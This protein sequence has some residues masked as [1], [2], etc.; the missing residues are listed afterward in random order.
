MP[1]SRHFAGRTVVRWGIIGCG[2]VTEV[3]SGPGFQKASG[4]QL[5]AVMRRNG[6]LAADYAKRHGVPRWYDSAAALIA[7]PDVDA[8]YIATPP[9]SHAEYALAAAAAGKPA[10]VEKP[11][12]RHGAECDRMVEAFQRANLPLFVAYY[13]RRLPCFLKVE[14]LLK[15]GAIGRL[16]G[17][18]YRLAE[19]HHRKGGIWRTDPALAGAGHFLDVGS[20]ALDLLDYLLGPLSDV[21]GTAVN[22]ASTYSVEDSVALSFRAARG[23]LGSMVWNFAGAVSDDTMRL[24]GTDGEITFTMFQSLPVKLQTASGVQLFDLPYPPH[25]AQPLIQTVVDDLLGRG[26]C[27]ST[28]ES[29]RR[30]TRVMDKVLDAYYGGRGDSFWTRQETWPG[31]RRD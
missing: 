27:P 21:S 20:H 8:V 7:D 23:A 11:M 16:T 18:T 30:T 6:G 15:S 19:P 31:R 13:R 9:D 24:L 17:I 4:S 26:L 25:V 22:V 10:Y 3:K 5:V 28:G 2:D 29:A 14:E 1:I 12:A